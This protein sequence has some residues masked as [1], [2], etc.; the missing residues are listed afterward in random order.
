MG[1]RPGSLLSAQGGY[2]FESGWSP[3]GSLGRGWR[4]GSDRQRWPW[5]PGPRVDDQAAV[6]DRVRDDGL[7]EQSV[8]QQAAPPRVASVEAECELV[9]VRI[10]VLGSDRTL[11]GAEHPALKQAR[12]AMDARHEDVSGV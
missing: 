5:S 10:E 8:E 9:E 7:L 4:R 6:R 3:P 11:V 12:D 2:L 1:D